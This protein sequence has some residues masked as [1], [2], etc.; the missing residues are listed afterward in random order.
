MNISELFTVR[1]HIYQY[2][3][4][5][6]KNHIMGKPLLPFSIF[7]VVLLSGESMSRRGGIDKKCTVNILYFAHCQLYILL[8][9][10]RMCY[11]I[12]NKCKTMIIVMFHEHFA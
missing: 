1:P 3:N 5:C 2:Q 8:N 12:C 9:V 7:N 10:I 6:V 11:D 4:V